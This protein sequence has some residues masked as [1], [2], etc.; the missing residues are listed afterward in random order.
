[1]QHNFFQYSKCSTP[2]LGCLLAKQGFLYRGSTH[3]AKHLTTPFGDPVLADTNLPTSLQDLG[4][5]CGIHT[6]GEIFSWNTSWGPALD[7][8]SFLQMIC[9][10]KGVGS[11]SHW[12]KSSCSVLTII[13]TPVLAWES[14]DTWYDMM[15]ACKCCIWLATS[16]TV[17]LVICSIA[18]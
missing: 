17:R 15:P 5:G 14:P 8:T 7:L 3:V 6:R 13:R 1:M 2:A 18:G 4:G 9:A 11:S 12:L 16:C 10:W